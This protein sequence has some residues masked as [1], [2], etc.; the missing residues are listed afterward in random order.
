MWHIDWTREPSLVNSV[1]YSH[2]KHV[3]VGSSHPR[4]HPKTE[5]CT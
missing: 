2:N 5:Y 1:K 4:G 3:G